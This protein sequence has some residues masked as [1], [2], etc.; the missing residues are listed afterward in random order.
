MDEKPGKNKVKW[1]PIV[2]FSGIVKLNWKSRIILL[3]DIGNID[4]EILKNPIA[5][6]ESKILLDVYVTFGTDRVKT[7]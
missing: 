3:N 1:S 7:S 2:N 6:T 5:L 4:R